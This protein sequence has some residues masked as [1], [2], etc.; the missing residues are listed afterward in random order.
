MSQ[1]QAFKNYYCA[2]SDGDL[3]KVAENGQSLVPVAQRVLASEMVS[4]GLSCPGLSDGLWP[5][6]VV[7]SQEILPWDRKTLMDLS[8]SQSFRVAW[9]FAWRSYGLSVLFVFIGMLVG[10]SANRVGLGVWAR[11]MLFVPL[12]VVLGLWVCKVFMYDA[13]LRKQFREFKIQMWRKFDQQIAAKFSIKEVIAVSWLLSWRSAIVGGVV[14]SMVGLV[15]GRGSTVTQ[16]LF[17]FGL[18]QGLF[19]GS[20]WAVRVM[21]RKQFRG[22][23]LRAVRTKS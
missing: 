2:M 17:W 15:A 10:F 9:F 12:F 6:L 11:M 23:L 7:Q 21:L 3:M 4:R 20:P 19:F 14:G 18:L 1:E 22:F 16:L 13:V 8:Y 5:A